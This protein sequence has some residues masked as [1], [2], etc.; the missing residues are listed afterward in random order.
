MFGEEKMKSSRK[1]VLCFTA[2]V[3]YACSF[4]AFAT[5]VS[6][7]M[8]AAFPGAG[9]P[10]SPPPWMT[11]TFDDGGSS[12]TVILTISVPGLT[13]NG[14]KVDSVYFNLAEGL[15]PTQLVFSNPTILAGGVQNI[16][17]DH[18][19]YN[20]YQADGDGFYDVRL[21]F[22]T[23]GPARAFNGGDV[24]QYT[25]ALASL[26]ANSFNFLSDPAPGGGS[27]PY[28]TAA[29]LQGVVSGGGS[30]WVTI[31]EPATIAILGLGAL[32]LRK[33]A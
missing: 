21:S 12:G 2:V 1:A 17:V 16:V 6:F 5:I 14:Q 24:I 31:P 22:D 27:G 23:D 18:T 25:I 13:G 9:V 32:V 11:A 8:S 26:T 20:S 10:V 19:G 15:D 33:K 4:P 3:I 7:D 29:H 30:A 28:K